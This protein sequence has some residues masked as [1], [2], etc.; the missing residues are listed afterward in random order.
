LH[1]TATLEKCDTDGSVCKVE[2]GWKSVTNWACLRV[3][4]RL[5]SV[6]NR[7]FAREN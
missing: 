6:T 7:R 2:L 1:G 3:K 5:E 4:T